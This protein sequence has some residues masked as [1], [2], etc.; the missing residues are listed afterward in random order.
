MTDETDQHDFLF[1]SVLI[2]L[3]RAYQWLNFDHSTNQSRTDGR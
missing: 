2:R 1:E 3:I